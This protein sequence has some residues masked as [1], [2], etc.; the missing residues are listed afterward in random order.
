MISPYQTPTTP[1]L[2]IISYSYTTLFESIYLLIRGCP[3]SLY[4]ILSI[5]F[6]IG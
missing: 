1:L 5:Y 3:F 4:I 2:P 6:L